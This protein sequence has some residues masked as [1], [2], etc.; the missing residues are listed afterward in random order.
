M[1]SIAT[2]IETKSVDEA[3]NMIYNEIERIKHKSS[4]KIK[5]SSKASYSKELKR[6]EEKKQKVLKS[7]SEKVDEEMI[8]IDR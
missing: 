3:D 2:S 1:K 6:L 7:T 5:P 8:E 4:G